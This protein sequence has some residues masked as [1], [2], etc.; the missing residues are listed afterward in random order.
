MYLSIIEFPSNFKYG[1]DVNSSV[2]CLKMLEVPSH[3]VYNFNSAEFPNF[4]E[5]LKFPEFSKFPKFNKF[6]NFPKSKLFPFH[7]FIGF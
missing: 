6:P 7:R 4:S 1:V 2:V 3:Y 5:F